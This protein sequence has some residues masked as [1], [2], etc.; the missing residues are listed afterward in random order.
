MCLAQ[1]SAKQYQE[2]MQGVLALSRAAR[3]LAALFQQDFGRS[4][5][6]MAE[7]AR[8]DIGAP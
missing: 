8:W 4:P 1:F 5:D 2:G 3:P 7:L 6:D